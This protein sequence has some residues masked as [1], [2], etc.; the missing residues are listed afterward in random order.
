[1][2]Q[3][4][5]QD[6]RLLGLFGIT[7]QQLLA[8]VQRHK[9]CQELLGISPE[10][11]R[12]QD[13]ALWSTWLESYKRRL[14]AELAPTPSSSSTSTSTVP[15]A[16]AECS[17]TDAERHLAVSQERVRVMNSNNPRV[18][19]RN[20]IAQTAI[21]AAEEGDYSKVQIVLKMLQNPYAEESP[22]DAE[23]FAQFT[24]KPPEWASRIRVTCSS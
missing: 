21:E 6:P 11:K 9:Q 16:L 19:L 5:Q 22:D 1:M 14:F 13:S 12:A 23:L 15:S 18:V 8:E 3:L 7:H 20:Y 2:L 24:S 17:S 10:E 4:A